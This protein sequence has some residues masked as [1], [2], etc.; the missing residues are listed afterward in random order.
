MIPDSPYFQIVLVCLTGVILALLMAIIFLQP[1]SVNY[2]A[3]KV[4][5]SK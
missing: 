5:R 4:L 2:V 1:E 3:F